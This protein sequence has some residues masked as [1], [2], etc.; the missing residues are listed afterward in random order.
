MNRKQA[1]RKFLG[2]FKLKYEPLASAYFHYEMLPVGASWGSVGETQYCD[3]KQTF[4]FKTVL[5]YLTTK[6]MYVHHFTKVCIFAKHKAHV[7]NPV[8][9]VWLKW[10]LLQLFI[11]GLDFKPYLIFFKYFNRRKELTSQEV[12]SFFLS[13]RYN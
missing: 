6:R 4:T 5:W 8:S 11:F 1:C 7:Y 2:G 3:S 13:S 12:V 9:E 10:L